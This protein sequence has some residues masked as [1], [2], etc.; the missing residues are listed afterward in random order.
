MSTTLKEWLVKTIAE[1]EEERDATPGAVNEDAANALAAMKIALASLEAEPVAYIFKHPAGRLFWSLTDESNK[2]QSDVMPVYTAQPA[3][4]FVPDELTREEYKRRFM[5]DDDFD[6][7]F[8]G[9]WKAHRAA[10]LQGSQP[11][12]NRDELPPQQ[13]VE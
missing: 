3:P 9:G 5:E 2:G 1:L 12:S 13:Q 6:D 4:V 10:N 11:V 7:T 8:R